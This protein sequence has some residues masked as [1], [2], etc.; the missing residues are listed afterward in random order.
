MLC[1]Y[2]S[3][4]LQRRLQQF[5]YSLSDTRGCTPCLDQ[6]QCTRRTQYFVSTPGRS[7]MGDTLDCFGQQ[8]PVW[9]DISSPFF[10]SYDY[11]RLWKLPFIQFVGDKE[12]WIAVEN[13]LIAVSPALRVLRLADKSSAGKFFLVVYLH[14]NVQLSSPVDC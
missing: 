9:R 7:M 2:S 4:T 14:F 6:V 8:I 3:P 5:V 13:L 1:R 11:E 10:A 12:M